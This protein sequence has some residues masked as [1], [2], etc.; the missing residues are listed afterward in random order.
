MA[1]K[2]EMKKDHMKEYKK[3]SAKALKRHMTEEKGL[4]K[5]KEHKKK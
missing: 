1:K 4:L 5:T 3:M 2:V